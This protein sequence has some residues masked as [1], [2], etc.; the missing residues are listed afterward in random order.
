[1]AAILNNLDFFLLTT[2][3]CHS[4]SDALDIDE[5]ASKFGFRF[6]WV[7]CRTKTPSSIGRIRAPKKQIKNKPNPI[8][9][10]YK[11]IW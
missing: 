10:K 8:P 2:D 1:M 3:G 5:A 11:P 7:N 4:L 9:Q 6:N